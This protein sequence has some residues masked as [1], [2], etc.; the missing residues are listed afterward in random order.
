[1]S[2]RYESPDEYALRLEREA[3]ERHD[4]RM[5]ERMTRGAILEAI[6]NAQFSTEH[7]GQLETLRLLRKVFE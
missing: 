7:D 4:Y 1:M 5:N 3:A 2:R 6:D